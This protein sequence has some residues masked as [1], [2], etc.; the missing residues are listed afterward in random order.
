MAEKNETIGNEAFIIGG[1]IIIAAILVSAALWYSVSGVQN[2]LVHL[3]Q[4]PSGAAAPSG[5][6]AGSGGAQ[7]APAGDW[8]FVAADP[9]IGPANAKV[10]VVEFAD[11]Q[12]PFCA[13]AFGSSIGGAQYDS[14]RG[15]ATKLITNYAN[16]GKIRFVY[17]PMSFLGQESVDATNAAFCARATGGDTAFFQM[18]D[19]LFQMQGGENSGVFTKANLKAYAAQI[20]LGSTAMANCIDSGTYNA[21]AEQSNSQANAAGV[22]GTPMFAINNVLAT[23]PDYASMSAQVDALLAK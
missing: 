10:T 8:S 3:Q 5:N 14:L 2:S 6:G 22:Q 18:H 12:C 13:I 21:Q 11:F 9:S 7:A 15:A 20:G 19:K 1:A 16:S 17:H 4:L 23:S